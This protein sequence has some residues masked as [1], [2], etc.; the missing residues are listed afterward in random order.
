[1]AAS[2]QVHAPELAGRVRPEASAVR[3]APRLRLLLVE[4]N[5]IDAMRVRQLLSRTKGATFSIDSVASLQ[6]GIE[7]LVTVA[8]DLVLLDLDLPDSLG[9]DTVT[10][11]AAASPATPIVVLCRPTD[12][13]VGL[14]AVQAGAQDYVLKQSV[15]AEGLARVVRCAVERHRVVNSLR[16]L[17]LTDE[18]TGLFN[19]RG[20]ATLAQGHL[21]LA[22]R[23]GQQFV[24]LFVDVDGLKRINDEQGHHAG[25]LALARVAEVLRTTFRQSDLVARYGGDEFAILAVDLSGD[26]G[27]VLRRRLANNLAAANAKHPDLPPLSLSIGIVSLDGRLE[28]PLGAL[29]SRADQIL[30]AD[31]KVRRSKAPDAPSAD[32]TRRDL[33]E[34]SRDQPGAIRVEGLA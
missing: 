26:G 3:S 19:R 33:L 20:F 34:D 13:A 2:V 6:A 15:S 8:F 17:S 27:T 32:G 5:P 9:L 23:T 14:E 24:L 1:M 30:Y 7:R 25:D 28:E 21:R 4:D 22:G 10:S 29:L 31:R 12:E 18:L 16:G 11:L